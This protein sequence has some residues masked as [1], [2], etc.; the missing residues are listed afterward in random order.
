MCNSAQ[1][2]WPVFT[3][4][5]LLKYLQPMNMK[6]GRQVHSFCLCV[7]KTCSSVKTLSMTGKNTARLWSN[8]KWCRVLNVG[9]SVY[10]TALAREELCARLCYL[11]RIQRCQQGENRLIYLK[12]AAAWFHKA[13]FKALQKHHSVESYGRPIS[14]Q[15]L[16]SCMYR[17]MDEQSIN[18]NKKNTTKKFF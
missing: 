7:E 4:V 18:K 5:W 12:S 8:V 9:T 3:L 1:L 16:E 17:R 11:E 14:R 13:S 15:E 2:N 6:A 10:V